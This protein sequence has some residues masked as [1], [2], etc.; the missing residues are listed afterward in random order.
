M[1]LT[2][3]NDK[4]ETSVKFARMLYSKMTNTTFWTQR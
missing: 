1:I 3:V 2:A 4:F